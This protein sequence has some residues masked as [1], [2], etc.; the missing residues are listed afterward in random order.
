MHYMQYKGG[1]NSVLIID[2]QGNIKEISREEAMIIL[3][4]YETEEQ[5]DMVA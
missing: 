2:E 1:D 4:K 3:K 5:E